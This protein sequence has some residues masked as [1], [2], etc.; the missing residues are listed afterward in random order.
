MFK[1]M[2]LSFVC[3]ANWDCMQCTVLRCRPASDLQPQ[4]ACVKHVCPHT[5][6]K[7]PELLSGLSC[8]KACPGTVGAHSELKRLVD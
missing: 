3:H 5:R 6:Q 4:G 1:R 8:C 7:S 2:L